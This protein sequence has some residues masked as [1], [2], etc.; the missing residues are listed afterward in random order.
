MTSHPKYQTIL[1]QLLGAMDSFFNAFGEDAVQCAVATQKVVAHAAQLRVMHIPP[2]ARAGIILQ[3]R[4][5]G[6]ERKKHGYPM[7]FYEVEKL[8]KELGG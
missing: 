8:I 6:M 5:K 2:K 3:L 1:T 7:C 4:E